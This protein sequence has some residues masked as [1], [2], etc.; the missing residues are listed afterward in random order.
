MPAPVKR[1][2]HAGLTRELLGAVR[3]HGY[4]T[5]TPIQCQALPI[6]LSGRDMIG[7]AATGSGKTASYLLPAIA[8]AIVQPTVVAGE[9]P[10]VLVVCPTHE[11]CE[12]IVLE[13]RKFGGKASHGLRT[14][15]VYGG[16]NKYD[17]FKLLKAGAEV[18]VGTPGRLIELIG[19]KSGNGASA[20]SA[21]PTSRVTLLILDEA[22]RMFSL[23]FEPQ[24]PN[25][26][27]HIIPS[28]Q[29]PF[30]S[31]SFPLRFPFSPPTPLSPTLSFSLSTLLS[32]SLFSLLLPLSLSLSLSLSL[33][34]L[35]T[36][37]FSLSYSFS[38][39]ASFG[40]R[41]GGAVVVVVVVEEE[42]GE[43]RLRHCRARAG[44]MPHGDRTQA[45]R[46]EVVR[47]FKRGEVRV[48]IATDVAS[49]GLDIPAIKTVVS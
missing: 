15:G 34:S 4:D 31:P 33:F 49:R 26:R 41:K 46:Q 29:T 7:I 35:S 17:Q 25:R 12:Q 47:A 1:F 43:R 22:D 30:V 27:L 18:V 42:G 21:L 44:R 45:E 8:H 38:S 28:F 24:V 40:R 20:H 14:I 19:H 37:T 13:A 16:V 6:A 10:I 9:G 48:L 2:E 5:P 36:P 32:L 23:G 11:L 3:R 39:S